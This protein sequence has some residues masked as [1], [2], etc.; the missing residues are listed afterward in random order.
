MSAMKHDI[1]MVQMMAVRNMRPLRPHDSMS[2][3]AGMVP[4]DTTESGISNLA[5]TEPCINAR[6]QYTVFITAPRI[7]EIFASRPLFLKMI[8]E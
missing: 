2:Q 8:V 1:K 5:G 6:L 7:A 3:I 4:L